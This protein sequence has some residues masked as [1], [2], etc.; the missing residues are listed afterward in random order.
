MHIKGFWMT[1]QIKTISVEAW[2]TDA[3]T[4]QVGEGEKHHK[5]AFLPLHVYHVMFIPTDT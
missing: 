5:V 1:Q 3:W 4:P 2:Q